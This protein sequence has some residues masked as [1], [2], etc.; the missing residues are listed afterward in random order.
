MGLLLP[1][2][3]YGCIYYRQAGSFRDLV[4]WT[5]TFNI[6]GD[7]RSLGRLAMTAEQAIQILPSFLMTLPFIASVAFP[8][9]HQRPARSTRIWLLLFLAIAAVNLYPRYSSRHWATALPFLAAVSG[10][11]CG[12]LLDG[13]GKERAARGHQAGLY[14]AVVLWWMVSA[15]LS[16]LPRL[17]DPQPQHVPEYG[18]LVELAE[19][20]IGK[21]ILVRVYDKD[22]NLSRLAG[23]NKAYVE[24]HLPHISRSL[25]TSLDNLCDSEVIVI[26]HPI[27]CSHIT[28]WLE[29]GRTVV[30]LVGI[31]DSESYVNYSGVAW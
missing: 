13:W 24:E 11:A 7:Y 5:L 26:G 8:A 21:G 14:A 18:D 1:L 2:A 20:L 27:A 29:Q 3:A 28:V 30:D 16:Y 17:I 10:I 25:V 31:G 23:K 6:V 4:Y 12:D 9:T 22:V 15:S 19:R